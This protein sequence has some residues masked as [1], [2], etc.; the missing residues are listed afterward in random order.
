MA[1][2]ASQPGSLETLTREIVLEALEDA[3]LSAPLANCG[4]VIGS[5]RG[6]Q[7]KWESL[8]RQQRFFAPSQISHAPR[9]TPHSLF[10]LH[11]WLHALP[12]TAAITAAQLIETSAAVRSPMAACATG[13]WAIAQGYALIQSGEYDQVIAGAVEAPITPLTLTGFERMGALAQTGS[14]PFDCDREGLVLGEGGAALVL[15][16]AALAQKRSARIYGQ[17][18]GFG[19]TADGYHVSAPE[20][21]SRAAIAA[22]NQCLE[23]SGLRSEDIQYIHAHGTATRLNDQNEAHLIQARFPPEVAISSTKGATGH[24]IGASGAL[25][26]VFCLLAIHHQQL[27]PN[28]GLRQRAFDLNLV[29]TTQAAAI[30]QA[31]CFSFGFGGQNAAIACGQYSCGQ[32]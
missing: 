2:I 26:V 8:A 11:S 29:T 25:G 23:H 21:E 15:E 1:L 31:L 7:G 27:P 12:H 32:Y 10:P 28:V 19:L 16:S 13:L 22:V 18:L 24:T 30:R 5:S 9:P 6:N 17:I 14:Y 4:V 20:P 3:D